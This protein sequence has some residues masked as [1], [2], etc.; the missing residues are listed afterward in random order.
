MSVEQ[1]SRPGWLAIASVGLACLYMGTMA[2][3]LLGWNA[4]LLPLFLI[5]SAYVGIVTHEAG[6]V[7]G[8][9]AVGYGVDVFSV[10]PLQFH[11]RAAGWQVRQ[12][13]NEAPLGFIIPRLS[14]SSGHAARLAFLT[15][16]GPLASFALAVAAYWAPQPGGDGWLNLHYLGW[17]SALLGIASLV[18]FAGSD[19]AQLISLMKGGSGD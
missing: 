1:N 3:Y 8:S 7:L 12:I 19:G 18:P 4:L 2:A 10:W 9:F 16:M 15:A 6:H 11:R 14:G 17:Y 5:S 13:A